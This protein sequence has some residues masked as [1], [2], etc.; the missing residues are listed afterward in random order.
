VRHQLRRLQHRGLYA[1]VPKDRSYPHSSG[2][3]VL[4]FQIEFLNTYDRL[5]E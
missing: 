5:N 4:G 1:P 2:A 3:K